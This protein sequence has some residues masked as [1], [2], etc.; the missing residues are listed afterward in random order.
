MGGMRYQPF[1][2]V[3]PAA[4]AGLKPG[5][6]FFAGNSVPANLSKMKIDV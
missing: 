3:L 1:L 6:L 5:D 2:Y 4:F